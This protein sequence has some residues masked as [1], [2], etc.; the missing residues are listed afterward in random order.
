MKSIED[1]YQIV[2]SMQNVDSTSFTVKNIRVFV[3]KMQNGDWIETNRFKKYAY[4]N[5][6]IGFDV[7]NKFSSF[8]N[9]LYIIIAIDQMMRTIVCDAHLLKK[10]TG[11]T[12]LCTNGGSECGCSN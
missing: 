5:S 1:F 11:Y 4:V 7:R 2:Y 10:C 12:T 8:G 6:F 9:T 3:L